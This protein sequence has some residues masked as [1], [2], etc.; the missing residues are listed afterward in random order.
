MFERFSER[1]R[2]VVVQAQEE[3]RALSHD[4]I[5]TEHLLLGLM[6]DEDATSCRVLGDLGVTPDAVR[7]AVT[8]SVGEAPGT[9]SPAT[10]PFSP[11][12][13]KSL[14]LALREALQLGHD[15][16]STGHILLG[17]LR[18]NEGT[19]AQVLSDLGIDLDEARHRV[20][21]AAYRPGK[22]SR[23]FGGGPFTVLEQLKG[24]EQRLA[25]AEARLAAVEERLDRRDGGD[26]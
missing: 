25:A 17:L 10:I 22:G 5:G 23:S 1:A 19:A 11:R 8:G 16:I 21:V 4:H 24:V 13:K 7:E 14:E 18:E 3:A 2:K 9:D 12:A 26:R 20:Q 15:Y 6:H